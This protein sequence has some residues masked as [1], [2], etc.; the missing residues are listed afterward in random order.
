MFGGFPGSQAGGKEAQPSVPSLLLW[1]HENVPSH[2]K[3]G[4]EHKATAEGG[5]IL[6]TASGRVEDR[7]Q[8]L[9]V[10]TGRTTDLLCDLGFLL[11]VPTA[12]P[13]RWGRFAPVSGHRED[14][15]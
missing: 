1:H 2:S 7:V 13:T 3:L 14:T 12:F 8:C 10:N 4:T 11:W 6:W 9:G 5:G 15:I